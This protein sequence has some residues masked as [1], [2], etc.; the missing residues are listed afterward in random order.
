MKTIYIADDG[1][2]FEKEYECEKYERRQREASYNNST[3]FMLFDDEGKRFT[4]NVTDKMDYAYYVYIKNIDNDSY[5]YT[6]LKM[7]CYPVEDG[8]YYYSDEYDGWVSIDKIISE[9]KG[10]LKHYTSMK[11]KIEGYIK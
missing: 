1:T 10:K 3:S 9:I 5:L 2:Q 8:L 4:E 6:L 7:N 11:E